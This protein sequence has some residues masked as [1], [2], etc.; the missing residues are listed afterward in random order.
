[1]LKVVSLS[2]VGEEVTRLALYL[3][4]KEL[5]MVGGM[6]SDD[7]RME[8]TFTFIFVDDDVCTDAVGIMPHCLKD[9]PLYRHE[10]WAYSSQSS[11]E[12]YQSVG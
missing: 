11:F 1:M 10:A 5:E 6:V 7:F 4:G 12:S 3:F 2:G 9:A 8:K